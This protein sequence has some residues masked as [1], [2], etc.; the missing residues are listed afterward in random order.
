[1]SR[2]VERGCRG[3]E[4][5]RKW[6]S[7]LKSGIDQNGVNEFEQIFSSALWKFYVRLAKGYKSKVSQLESSFFVFPFESRPTNR[8][9]A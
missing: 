1:M 6:F 5:S 4:I 2:D 3:M 8:Q 7:T 9:L